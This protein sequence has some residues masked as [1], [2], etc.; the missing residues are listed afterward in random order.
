MDDRVGVHVNLGIVCLEY[1]AG[2]QER[3]APAAATEPPGE[4]QEFPETS[5]V[6]TGG[7]VWGK[8]TRLGE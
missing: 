7:T 6:T 8:S 4:V 5:E 3:E 2:G 1:E